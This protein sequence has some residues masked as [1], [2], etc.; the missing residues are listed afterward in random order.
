M[1]RKIIIEMATTKVQMR[2]YLSNLAREC[3]RHGVSDRCAASLASAFLQDEGMVNMND[4]SKVIDKNKI[5]R[6]RI[7]VRRQ[8][9]LNFSS[10]ICGLYFDDRKDKTRSQVKKGTK[11]YGKV[12]SEE[13]VVL[14]KEPNS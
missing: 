8:E 1:N 12:I 5:R 11:Y 4:K 14:V 7:K 3:D 2:L 13:H 6:E 9:R 10:K